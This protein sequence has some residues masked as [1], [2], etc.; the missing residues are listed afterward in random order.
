M[1][2][3]IGVDASAVQ[4]TIVRETIE[5]ADDT[6]GGVFPTTPDGVEFLEENNAWGFVTIS[7]KPDFVAMYV[8]APQKE[9]QYFARVKSIIGADIVELARSPNTYAKYQSDKQVIEFESDSL[10]E[11]EDP[12]P[13]REKIPRSLRYTDLGRFREATGTDDLF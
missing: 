9:V 6:L 3:D 2:D 1:R 10:Y 12:I 5:G 7:Q 13:Y 8:S 4:G 11:L